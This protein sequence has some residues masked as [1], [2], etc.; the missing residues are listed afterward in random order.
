M[1]LVKRF[2][3]EDRKL[4]WAAALLLLGGLIIGFLWNDSGSGFNESG[5][6]IYVSNDF[7]DLI[8]NNLFAVGTIMLG[9]VTFGVLS[10]IFLLYNGLYIGLAIKEAYIEGVSIIEI[11]IK[12][13]PHGIWEIPAL[14]LSGVLGFKSLQLLLHSIFLGQ[15]MRNQITVHLKKVVSLIVIIVIFV[16][17][18]ATVE[19]YITP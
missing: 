1:K 9:Y 11:V 12:I 6:E 18:A 7:R 5:A 3:H 14:I 16:F 4:F 15:S 17:L 2:I 19:I 8:T 13:I 10:I